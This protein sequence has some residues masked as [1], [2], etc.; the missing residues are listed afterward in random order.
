MTVTLHQIL[1]QLVERVAFSM[2][3]VKKFVIQNLIRKCEQ[4]EAFGDG[5][6]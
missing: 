5:G 4:E 6:A 1:T 2:L 3:A